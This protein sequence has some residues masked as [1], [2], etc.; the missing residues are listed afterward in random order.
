KNFIRPCYWEDPMPLAPE[1]LQKIHF[2]KISIEN[3][4]FRKKIKKKIKKGTSKK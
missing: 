3:L 1:E 4:D 2:Y